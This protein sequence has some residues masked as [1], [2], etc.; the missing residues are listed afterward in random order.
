ME[1]EKKALLLEE[2]KK[3]F[4]M[5]EEEKAFF[6]SSARSTLFSFSERRIQDVPGRRWPVG[7]N[8]LGH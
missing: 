3:V 6:F 1:E 5:E 7:T 2:G 4:L 8:W